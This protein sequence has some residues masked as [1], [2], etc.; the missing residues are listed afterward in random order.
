[1]QAEAH[2][3]HAAGDELGAAAIYKKLT[4]LRPNDPQLLTLL[5][6]CLTARGQIEEARTALT[7]AS[8]LKP[9]D[10]AILY[11]LAMTYRR[12]G[13]FDQAHQYLDKALRLKPDDPTITSA[14]AACYYIAGDI[15]AANATLAPLL[16]KGQR[17]ISLVLGFAR[18][19]HRLAGGGAG[20]GGREADGIALLREC[21]TQDGIPQG[22]RVDALFFLGDLH[23]RLG[24]YDEAFAAY[25]EGNRLAGI[26]FSPETFSESVD[27][28]IQRTWTA[29]RM[30][31]FPRSKVK[32][33]ESE[34]PVFI[35][36]MPR[37]GTSLVEQILASHPQVYGAGEL[38]D[39]PKLVHEWQGAVSGALALMTDL[40]P[41]TQESVDR[42]AREY[43]GRIKRLAPRAKRITNK[44][45]HNFLHVGLISLLF[46]QAKVIHCVRDPMDTCLSCYFQNFG[47]HIPYAYDLSHAGLFYRDYQR[48][49]RHWREVLDIP[50]MDV[51]Y[52]DLVANQ[53]AISRRM[54]EFIGLEWND[55]C[56]RFHENKR[57]VLT[58]SNDQVRRPMYSSSVGRWRKYKKHLG[59]L[60]EAL[61][62]L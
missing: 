21:L 2:R 34:I 49:M 3:R 46:P 15:D 29:P 61:G 20:G 54:V 42:E 18:I 37:S 40:E 24:Q 1:M 55:A 33:P 51:G 57:V 56:L 41:L 30:K 53:E 25:A 27:D 38:N 12:E 13:R 47:G 8:R 44:M 4:K 16:D 32:P 36:G 17:H 62:N 52:E 7:K 39:I 48:I 9:N 45:P 35:L 6:E 22:L 31:E 50:I 60:K 11:D 19:C 43:L 5:G 14:K 23:D 26:R 28:L 59:P 58:M 10:P